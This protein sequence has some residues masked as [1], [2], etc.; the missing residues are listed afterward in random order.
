MLSDVKAHILPMNLFSSIRR[1][2]F[3]IFCHYHSLL[4]IIALF[5]IRPDKLTQI[6][7][8]LVKECHPMKTHS[9][10]A[11]L[12]HAASCIPLVSLR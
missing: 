9:L 5:E 11:L 1:H 3:R 2:I 8:L 7:T 10:F 6:K 12:A 4:L